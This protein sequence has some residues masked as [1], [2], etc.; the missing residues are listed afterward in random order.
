MTTLTLQQVAAG[1][2][3]GELTSVALT[4]CALA[5]ID[6]R[7]GEGARVFT[8]VYRDEARRQA[9]D[10]DQRRAAGQPRSALDGVPLSVKDL[11]DVAGEATTAGSRVLADAPAAPRHAAV[12]ARLLQAGVVLIGKTNMTEFAY[13]G[14]GINP[15]YGTPANPWDRAAR[16]IPG[17]SSSGA[18]VSVSDGMCF[19]ALGSDTG[20]SVRIPAAF[21]GLTG[22]KPTARRID[23]AGL[24]PLS[25]S[26]DSIGA[27]GRDVADCIALDALVA[28]HALAPEEKALSRARFAV[29]Q[30]LVLEGLDPD[31]SAAFERSLQR[32]ARA[33][34]RIEPVACTAF[35]ELAAINAGGGF[36]ALE[37]WR[38]H[39]TLIA[40]R[41]AEYDPRVL[42]RIRRGA[43]LD[44]ND[45]LQLETR[46]AD[47]QR[48]VTAE[49]RDFDA[50]LMPTVPV[51]APTIAELEADEER[52]FRINGAALRNP[53]VINFLD[54]CALSLPCQRPG[55]A[56][57][58]LMV[59]G[60]PLS[61]D[62]LLGW[63]LAIER[64]LADA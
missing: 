64:C 58:G 9:R 62:A 43:A 45:R 38:R 40:E 12:V 37:S 6:D 14:L 1:L 59:A 50:L 49:V 7:A 31:V 4:E 46:R 55:D 22:Y 51:I 39:R 47:W 33:G 52:Y 16:R 15:H 42:S 21:C 57:V 11:F 56:P 17:G 27:I 5:R 3:N 26:L 13:S 60:L 19:G 20:G 61:D 53:S 36:S 28:H 34:A 25:T 44:E 24:L 2:A 29:P 10:A 30:T 54:G 63:A 35:A 23:D 48:R 18:A 41:A 8:R 32:L